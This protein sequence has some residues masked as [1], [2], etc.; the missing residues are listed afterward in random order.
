MRTAELVM[1]HS[2]T[3]ITEPEHTPA[4]IKMILF[5]VHNDEAL[6]ARLQIALSLARTFGARVHLLHVTPVEAYTVT[7]SFAT[8]IGAELVAVLESEAAN[9]KERLEKQLANEDVNWSYE[10]VTG[11]LMTHLAHRAA[12]A[13]LVITGRQPYAREFAGSST[14]LFGDMLQAIRTP[15]LI[16]GDGRKEIDL[17][18]SGLV[19]WNGSYEAANAMRAAVPLLKLASRV[20]VISVE[21]GKDEQF[22]STDALEY[23]SRH[24]IHAELVQPLNFV[25]GV[26]DTLV[27]E[28]I[29]ADASYIVMGGYGHSRA[30]EFLFGGVTRSLLKDCPVSLI[31]AH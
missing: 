12:F 29:R 21:E 18:G 25:D 28:A 11:S 31:I 14:A 26:P 24:G 1:E 30:G 8:Y 13:D 15:L 23:L 5:D 27:D 10:E 19:A 6:D 9:L 22:P 17:F 4:G 7:D 16:A 20:R 3:P 2:S